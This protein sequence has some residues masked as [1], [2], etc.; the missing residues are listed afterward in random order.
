MMFGGH[1]A[2]QEA[3]ANADLQVTVRSPILTLDTSRL[4]PET[5][6]GQQLVQALE[7]EGAAL[8]V[9]NR[10]LAAE[11]RE[12]ELALVDQRATLS[13]EDFQELAEAFDT[14]VQTIRQAQD[15]KQAALQARLD[16]QQRALFQEIN[17]ILA[18]IMREAGAVVV[19]EQ[20]SVL[21]SARGADITDLAI[22][23]INDSLSV[24]DTVQETPVPEEISQD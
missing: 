22:A 11:L 21:L 8:E 7:A 9:E 1:L 10:R 20:N 17:P 23:R 13:R 15:D 16:D 3:G 6:L 4:L 5:N 18:Q 24:P 2:A 14:K 19:V 12:Q